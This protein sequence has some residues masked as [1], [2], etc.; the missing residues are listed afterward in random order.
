MKA[1]L[2]RKGTR[3][4]TTITPVNMKADNFFINENGEEKRIIRNRPNGNSIETCGLDCSTA[5]DPGDLEFTYTLTGVERFFYC[6]STTGSDIIVNWLVSVPY[7]LL[8]ANPNNLS[9]L[10]KGEDKI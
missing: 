3:S 9:V 1:H 2:E 6:S 5:T 7:T 8:G 4:V 10:S